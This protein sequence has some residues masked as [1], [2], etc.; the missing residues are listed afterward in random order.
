MMKNSTLHIKY[1]SNVSNVK[2]NKIVLY[3]SNILLV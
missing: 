1:I 2:I 3:I